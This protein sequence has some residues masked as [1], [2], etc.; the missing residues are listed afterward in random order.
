MT[1]LI[2]VAF[3]KALLFLKK[4]ALA[5]FLKKKGKF[6]QEKTIIPPPQ[7]LKKHLEFKSNLNETFIVR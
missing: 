4:V 5:L 2:K 3:R 1:Q 7:V 6:R